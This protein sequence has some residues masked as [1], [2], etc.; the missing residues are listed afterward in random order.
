[1]KLKTITLK[2]SLP[3]ILLIGGIIGL[4]CSFILIN[5]EIRL[6]QNPSLK[7]NCDIN[8][9]ISCGSV[10]KSTQASI[11]GFSNP[12]IG[13]AVFPMIAVVGAAILAGATFKRWFWV[14]FQAGITLGAIFAYWLLYESVYQINA[15]CPFCLGVDVVTSTLFW[16]VTLYNIGEKHI[17]IPSAKLQPAFNLVRKHHLDLLVL[18]FLIIA[19]LILHHFWYYYGR[20]F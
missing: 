5:D 18:W 1:M 4:I 9:I 15:L 7:P 6:L 20:Y 13:M 16:Y 17:P 8:P 12:I 11:F 14:L 10:A 19:A 2:K 3:Y